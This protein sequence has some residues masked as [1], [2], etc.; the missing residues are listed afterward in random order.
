[1]NTNRRPVRNIDLRRAVLRVL[2]RAGRPLRLCDIV[3]T[4]EQEE[5]IAIADAWEATASQRLSNLLGWQV[6]QGRVRRLAR[7]IYVAVPE[8]IPRTTRWRI[9]HWDTLAHR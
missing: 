6:R 2:L 1:M 4:L 5:H 8:A 3:T 9:E 7:G